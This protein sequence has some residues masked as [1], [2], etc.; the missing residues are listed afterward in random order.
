MKKESPH[1]FRTSSLFLGLT[2][3]KFYSLLSIFPSNT[4]YI[5]HLC[6]AYLCIVLTAFHM[7]INRH[8]NSIRLIL[9]LSTFYRWGK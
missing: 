7:L 9:L 8:N 3:V 4:N 6:S 1:I 5:A 2:I